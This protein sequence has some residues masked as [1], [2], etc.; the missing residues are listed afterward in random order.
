VAAAAHGSAGARHRC[1][2]GAAATPSTVAVPFP[3]ATP[4]YPASGGAS[5]RGS[6]EVAREGA[7][8]GGGG[9]WTAR[10]QWKR[11]RPTR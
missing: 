3:A 2:Q 8:W 10:A 6:G 9:W 7:S 5:G 4:H 11:R 1:R